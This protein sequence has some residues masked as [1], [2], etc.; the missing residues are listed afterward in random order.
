MTTQLSG[1]RDRVAAQS[2]LEELL[3]RQQALPPRSRFAKFWGFSPLAADS[4]AWYRGAQG[5]VFVGKV[6]GQLP[7]EWTVFHALPVG[8]AGADIDHLVLGPGGIFAINTKHHGGKRI[9]VAEKG[10]M[11]S[12]QKQPYIRNSEFEAARV[13]KILH[14][15]MPHLPL[16]RA[17]LALVRPGSITIKK[18][19]AT[20]KVLDAVTLRR[21]LLK[22]PQVLTETHLVEL[23]TFV[24]S[25][26]TW[27]ATTSAPTPDLM[28]RFAELDRHVRSARLT[29]V[30]WT[31]LGIAA[32]A[33]VGM[34]VVLTLLEALIP[35]FRG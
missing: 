18:K 24:D 3:R 34:L 31:L 6:L 30:A 19:P 13:T 27:S 29:R 8:K 32:T 20:V 10:F 1:M 17:V 28:A 25:P 35:A 21:W 26:S 4:V 23:A 7:P 12:G 9:W 22:Q 15:R 14:E 2:V 16:A 5:E 11:V 33:V